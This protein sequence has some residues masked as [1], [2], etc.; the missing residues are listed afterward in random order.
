MKLAVAI[1]S[2]LIL[3][4]CSGGGVDDRTLTVAVHGEGCVIDLSSHSAGR[5][6]ICLGSQLLGLVY[7]RDIDGFEYQEGY[8]YRLKIARAWLEDAS[9]IGYRLV[10][11]I[12]QEKLAQ[13]VAPDDPGY[14][15]TVGP[16]LRECVGVGPQTCMVVDGEL[17]YRPI[18]GFDYQEGYTYLLKIERYDAWP[19]GDPPAD[20]SRFGY[21]L[22][23]LISKTKP[24]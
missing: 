6:G 3:V 13:T 22:V 21:R 20:A 5:G 14:I 2:C 11:V 10:E 4:A 9:R 7:W 15:V 17:F 16:E 12:R 1:V 23:D 8:S 19:D 24:G 18:N